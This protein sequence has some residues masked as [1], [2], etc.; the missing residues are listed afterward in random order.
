MADHAP[1]MSGRP[2]KAWIGASNRGSAGP[3]SATV[4]ARRQRTSIIFLVSARPPTLSLTMCSC[5]VCDV[6]RRR[7]RSRT[8]DGLRG[9]EAFSPQRLLHRGFGALCSH[10]STG[11]VGAS[12]N[13]DDERAHA[14]LGARRGRLRVGDGHASQAASDSG[15]GG[16]LSLCGPV[17]GRFSPDRCP[18][19][20]TQLR[21]LGHAGRR[22][23]PG[24]NRVASCLRR[25]TLLVT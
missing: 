6:R 2:S 19:R 16:N 5:S 13:D 10:G 1:S 4:H 24:S 22:R 3:P 9:H 21:P 23:V 12:V 17:S 18:V 14:E 8:R 15:A 20:R 11:I 25:R 7:T